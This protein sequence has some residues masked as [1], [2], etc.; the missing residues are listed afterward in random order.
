MRSDGAVER[1]H[2]RLQSPTDASLFSVSDSPLCRGD[3]LCTAITDCHQ[4]MHRQWSH[5]MLSSPSTM[6]GLH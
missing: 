6:L 1:P 4:N 3:L 5:L 2:D